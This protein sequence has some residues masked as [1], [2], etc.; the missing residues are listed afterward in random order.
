MISSKSLLY[1]PQGYALRFPVI[2]DWGADPSSSSRM[3]YQR[4]TAAAMNTWCEGDGCDFVISTGDNFYQAG[5]TSADDPRFDSSWR[6]MYDASGV[7]GLVWYQSVGNH[8]H[9]YDDDDRE[10]YQVEFCLTRDS[11]WWQ[12]ALYYSF[13]RTDGSITVDFFVLDTQSLRKRKWDHEAQIA[14]L[15]YELSVSTAD[16][17]VVIAHHPPYTSG[18]YGPGSSTMRR[19]VTPLLE[20]YNVDV[21]FMGHDHNLQHIS[22]TGTNNDVDYI[23]S[24]GGGGGGLYSQRPEHVT[25]LNNRGYTQRHFTRQNGFVGVE[26]NASRIKMEF[27]DRYSTRVYV[28][29]R[30]SQK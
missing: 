17:K 11:R 25:D 26:V 6:N 3:R 29:R 18:N 5:V 23:I 14:W 24:G 15:E 2:G 9:Y 21:I 22:K 8:D 7:R 4:E 27:Y 16:W 10:L 20:R 12:P 28:Y 30:Y 19:L 1:F 13:S